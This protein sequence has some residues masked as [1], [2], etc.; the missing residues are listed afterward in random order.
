VREMDDAQACCL[1]DIG[2]QQHALE[3][4]KPQ[5]YG[6]DIQIQL[7]KCQS[8]YTYTYL[9]SATVVHTSLVQDSYTSA[10][11]HTHRQS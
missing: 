3:G 7:Y 5:R 4:S 6:P 2:S 9:P 1:L 8:I 11:S 10:H